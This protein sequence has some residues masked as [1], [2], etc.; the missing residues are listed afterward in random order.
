MNLNKLLLIILSLLA[1]SCTKKP[2][3]VYLY[4]KDGVEI[5][6]GS[7]KQV[8]TGDS[9]SEVAFYKAE[10]DKKGI[11]DSSTE[12]TTSISG[13]SDTSIDIEK[14]KYT[15]SYR[16]NGS[17]ASIRGDINESY[18]TSLL[19]IT[20]RFQYRSRWKLDRKNQLTQFTS[21]ILD[22]V[23]T[24]GKYTCDSAGHVTKL[25]LSYPE[26]HREPD[27][28][29]YKY[30]AQNHMIEKSL[31][32]KDLLLRKTTFKYIGF[33][34]YKNWT[35]REVHWQSFPPMYKDSGVSVETRKIIYY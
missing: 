35:K 4:S 28:Y 11:I 20:N 14:I 23:N 27:L 8:F 17:V 33:D 13:I 24:L 1:A 21:G 19:M 22:T 10:F 6:N 32:D 34:S 16:E 30:D 15:I 7:V 3:C 18:G 26:R 12:K 31:N 5:L 25:E 2:K 9:E 29:Y